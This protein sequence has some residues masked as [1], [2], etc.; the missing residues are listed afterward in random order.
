MLQSKCL[1]PTAQSRIKASGVAEG[2]ETAVLLGT[3]EVGDLA[4][5]AGGR[6]ARDLAVGELE[7]DRQ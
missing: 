3:A 7:V 2:V 1:S 6:V 5:V 4:E